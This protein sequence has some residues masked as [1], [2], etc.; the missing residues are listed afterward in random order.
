MAFLRGNEFLLGSAV[1][2]SD[3][4]RFT[5]SLAP[6]FVVQAIPI[7]LLLAILLGLGRL[8]EDRELLAMQSLGVSPA[9]FV[10]AP[11]MLGLLL[12][13]VM[14]ALAMTWQPWGMA[15]L[16]SVA[17]D[18]IRRNL[19]SDIRSGTFHE[20]VAGF[21]LYAERVSPGNQWSNVLLFDARDPNAP[22]LAVAESG[23]VTTDEALSSVVFELSHGSAHRATR[24]TTDYATLEFENGSFRA[25]IGETFF[26]KNAFRST[27]EEHS[28]LEMQQDID[29]ARARGE[30]THELEARLHW[31]LGQ[32]LMPFAFA[33]L[34]TPL[35]LSRSGRGGGRGRGFL[36]TLG[37]YVAFY[38]LARLSVQIGETGAIPTWLAGQ[39]PN[40]LFIVTGLL[41]L[42]W[43]RMQRRSGTR[44]WSPTA[45]TAVP[46][47]RAQG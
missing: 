21:T 4:S 36:L 43:V 15:T 18:I 6:Q 8:S 44:T 32:M 41:L 35:A 26:Q 45:P 22:V 23:H 25:D 14:F 11:L 30:P 29:D 33:C 47:R 27:N 13:G 31:R 40:V 7:A 42:R 16:R 19:V 1:T 46:G 38:V 12:S 24:A 9:R 10:V 34:G 20:E 39:L 3:F 28:P 37:G 5:V 17:Q 2:L